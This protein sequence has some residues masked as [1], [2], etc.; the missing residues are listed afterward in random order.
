MVTQ[1]P[2]C[3]CGLG[4]LLSGAGIQ[5]DYGDNVF[6]DIE[7]AINAGKITQKALD[8]AVTRAF[9]TR[10]RLGEFDDAR[11]PFFGKYPI[12]LLDSVGHRQAA[13]KAVSAS[14]VL[15]QNLDDALPL[16]SSGLKKVA[17]IG[18]WSDCK[19]RRGG[20]GGSMGYL[21]NYKGQPSYINTVLDAVTEEAQAGNFQVA[22]AQGSEQ[23]GT[24]ANASLIAEA[25]AAVQGA[26]VVILSLG[27]GN[28]IEGE[29]RDRSEL[30]FPPPQIALLAAVKKAVKAQNIET[31]S[32]TKLVVAIM[33]AGGVDMDPGEI[34]AVIQLWYGGQVRC[35]LQ[36]ALSNSIYI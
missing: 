32:T 35:Y 6:N 23:V 16:P 9:L 11:N 2:Y 25:T 4:L 15:L 22:Y 8:D 33:S 18:P 30:T 29:G 28:D 19:D 17:V 20:Y 14:A 13:R 5:L 3:Q 10:F 12:E 21:N 1:C 36:R 34:D 24:K 27:L 7:N 31:G 26:D